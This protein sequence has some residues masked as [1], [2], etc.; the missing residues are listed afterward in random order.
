VCKGTYVKFR[1]RVTFVAAHADV[2][3]GLIARKLAGGRHDMQYKVR[4]FVIVFFVAELVNEALTRIHNLDVRP[5]RVAAPPLA[6]HLVY[7]T[8]HACPAVTVDD[9]CFESVLF[10]A[11][12]AAHQQNACGLC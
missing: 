9:H 6:S 8:L 4:D 7:R 12:N 10:D 2:D 1:A 3:Y 11:A 5:I